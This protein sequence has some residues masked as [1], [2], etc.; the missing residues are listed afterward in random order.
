MTGAVTG[1]PVLD[2]IFGEGTKHLVDIDVNGDESDGTLQSQLVIRCLL[3]VAVGWMLL[4]SSQGTFSSHRRIKRLR[5][6][7]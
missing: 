4:T 3:S 1:Q 2:V 6:T 5:S 7:R